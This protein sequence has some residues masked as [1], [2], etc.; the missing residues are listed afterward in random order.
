MPNSKST[1]CTWDSSAELHDK[2]KGERSIVE[3]CRIAKS[4]LMLHIG[5]E[6]PPVEIK[7]KIVELYNCLISTGGVARLQTSN[8]DVFAAGDCLPGPERFTHAAE[9][10]LGCVQ[11][12]FLVTR[13]FLCFLGGW[14][15]EEA[16]DA[17]TVDCDTVPGW[18][19]TLISDTITQHTAQVRPQ[20]PDN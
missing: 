18:K 6:T 10:W 20:N 19:Q 2:E 7:S 1:N 4:P 3:L 17:F 9:W 14:G 5:V 12:T 13:V 15:G 8:H 16:G 11:S